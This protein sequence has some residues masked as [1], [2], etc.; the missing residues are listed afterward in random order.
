MAIYHFSASIVSGGKGSSVVAAA[1]Y[2]SG[3]RLESGLDGLVKDY[4]RK[5]RVLYKDIMLPFDAPARLRNREVLWNEVEKMEGVKGRYARRVI[6][7]L[8]REPTLEQNIKL[9]KRFVKRA[10]TDRGMVADVAIHDDGLGNPHAHILLTMRPFNLDGTWGQ[11]SKSI[12]ERDADGKAIC[13]GRDKKGRKRYKHT[14]V[15]LTDWNSK[16]RLKV[17]R[18]EWADEANCFL[19]LAGSKARIDHR[20]Y[21]E[22]GIDKFP[23]KHRGPKVSQMEAKGI[24]T[25]VGNYNRLAEEYNQGKL[26]LTATEKERLETTTKEIEE[27][28]QK[29]AKINT[30]RAK[31][32]ALESLLESQKSEKNEKEKK[33]AKLKIDLREEYYDETKECMVYGRLHIQN[34]PSGLFAVLSHKQK[35]FDQKRRDALKAERKLEDEVEFLKC[36]IEDTQKELDFERTMLTWVNPEITSQKAKSQQRKQQPRQRG[37]YVGR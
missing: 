29:L 2:Q 16:D 13:I 24:K 25:E 28:N 3:E 5:E 20:S 21:K 33:L 36:K 6:L 14:T 34:R 1:A 35:E 23:T 31:V 18:K 30:Q 17:W 22:Q 27:I 7:A 32:E 15:N 9:L 19:A 8:P 37:M 26:Q 4:Q 11:K 12:V 10:F